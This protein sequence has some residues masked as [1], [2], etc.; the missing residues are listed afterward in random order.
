[1]AETQLV[2]SRAMTPPLR[3]EKPSETKQADEQNR[4]DNHARTV[5]G[6]PISND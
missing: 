6:R 1:L 5:A 2:A 3:V 4:A